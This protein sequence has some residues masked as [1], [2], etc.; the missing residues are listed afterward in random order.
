MKKSTVLCAD[1]ARINPGKSVNERWE[2]ES[3][4]PL[5][6]VGSFRE[7][8]LLLAVLPLGLTRGSSA[9]T[10]QLCYDKIREKWRGNLL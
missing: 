3:M 7:E 8:K 9:V 6:F 4:Y 2:P 1:V 10:F 5:R